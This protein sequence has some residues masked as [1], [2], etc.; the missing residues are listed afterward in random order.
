MHFYIHR[1]PWNCHFYTITTDL[2]SICR[3]LVAI[4][5]FYLAFFK[6]NHQVPILTHFPYHY[7]HVYMCAWVLKPLGFSKPFIPLFKLSS[8]PAILS[9]LS[10][11]RSILFP[12]YSCCLILPFSIRLSLHNIVSLP[13]SPAQKITETCR[14][15]SCCTYWGVAAACH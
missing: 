7:N 4:I 10:F 6:F 8:P 9:Q 1:K 5:T 11:I 15:L 13:F 3:R 14:Y 2:I 12:C